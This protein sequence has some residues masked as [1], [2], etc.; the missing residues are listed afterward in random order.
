MN[1]ATPAM[2]EMVSLG[3]T[4]SGYIEAWLNPRN[5]LMDDT[6]FVKAPDADFS[7][8]NA[9]P[10]A[11]SGTAMLVSPMSGFSSSY[12]AVALNMCGNQ[13]DPLTEGGRM[14]AESLLEMT[15]NVPNN[16]AV[17]DVGGVADPVNPGDDG[18]GC[19][20]VLQNNPGTDA[21]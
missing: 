20:H 7:P 13:G 18:N 2:G 15:T 14:I 9:Q 16:T 12:N 5:A 21:S 8:E 4:D 1:V 3:A 10:R 17:E 11:I 6:S 19:W